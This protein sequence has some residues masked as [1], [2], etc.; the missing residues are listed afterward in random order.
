MFEVSRAALA[1]IE[2][3]MR[4]YQGEVPGAAVLVSHAGR[5]LLR[6]AFGLAAL[7]SATA[8]T[9]AS[10]YRLASL[11]K[12]FTAAAILL[13]MQ[14]GAL[15]LEER[16]CRWLPSLPE[17]ARAVT[18]RHLLTHTS[19]LI[20]YEDLIAPGTTRPLRDADV[21][22]LLASTRRT[23][24]TPGSRYR[25]SD[26]G[27]AL[28]AL[29][30]E[31]VSGTDFASFLRRRLFLPLAMHD[32][33]ALEEGVSQPRARAFGYSRAHGSWSR[34]DQSLT[35]AVLGDGG[36][37]SSVDD[38]AKWDA[39]LYGAAPFTRATLDVA[40][41]PATDT[42]D[43]MT[44]YALGWRVTG[45]SVWHSGETL[46]FRTALVR[47]PRAQLTVGMLSNR[48]DGEPYSLALAI[49]KQFL[50]EADAVRA[51]RVAV[52]PD[53]AAHPLPLGRSV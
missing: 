8:A 21:L 36:I 24:F 11:S 12:P 30:V 41:A 15:E 53:P 16:V 35:S 18:V 29:L 28:L 20:D 51:T 42:D 50:P 34:T 23:Y 5:P 48:S 31:A 6:R 32:T 38:L 13:L 39:A 17:A 47:W 45:A 3:L 19:G 27:Y 10:A 52:G 1:N 33:V 49:A 26:S 22:C 43:P 37:Y 7:E 46:G 40:F 44:R 9:A 14:E 25:Y 4:D 2:V